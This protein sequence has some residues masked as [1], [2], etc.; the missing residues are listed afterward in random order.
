MRP[1]VY[2]RLAEVEAEHWWFRSRRAIVREL[3]GRLGLPD[4]PAILE[5]GCGT[6]GNLA[7][8]AGFGRVEAFEPSDAARAVAAARSDAEVRPGGLP[9]DV[10]Y[11]VGSF[12]LVCA[13]D[14]LEHVDDDQA[15]VATLCA[16]ARPDGHVVVT[17]PALQW[18]WSEHDVSHEHRRRYTRKQLGKVLAN[19]GLRIDRLSYFNTLLFP[20]I[21]NLRLVRRLLGRES[22]AVDEALPPAAVN[23]VL[24]AIFSSERHLLKEID[25]P[26]GVSLLAV[27]RRPA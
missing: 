16:M 25:L 27:A 15:A 3:I 6:G 9:D 4:A 19:A 1:E 26:I 11:T 10:P 23:R 22:G 20:L 8:L 21:A 13:F 7:L 12:D 24:E 2:A 18:L 14:V 17:V 5:A